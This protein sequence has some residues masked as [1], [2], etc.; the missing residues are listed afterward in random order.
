MRPIPISAGLLAQF[1]PEATRAIWTAPNGDLNDPVI[2]PAEAVTYQVHPTGSAEGTLW[3]VTSV[4][5]TL[6]EG[7]LEKLQAGGLIVLGFPG[8]RLPVFMLPE[9][10]DGN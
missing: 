4:V 9:V 10:I 7:D 2:P 6:E 5:L 3:P 8:T 1:G